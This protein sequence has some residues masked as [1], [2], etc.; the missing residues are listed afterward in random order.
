[1]AKVEID[2]SLC[3]G[4]GACM[5]ICPEVFDIGPDGLAII[6]KD[7]INDDV[8]MACE[9]CPVEAIKINEEN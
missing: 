6:K 4:C 9:G 2:E 8:I 5:A 7:E 3:I 1:M